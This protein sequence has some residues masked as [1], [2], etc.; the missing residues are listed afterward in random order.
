MLCYLTPNK[1]TSVLEKL[2][3]LLSKFQKKLSLKYLYCNVSGMKNDAGVSLVKVSYFDELYDVI[4]N[5]NG[6]IHK[7]GDSIL[8]YLSRRME[9]IK[10]DLKLYIMQQVAFDIYDDLLSVNVASWLSTNKESELYGKN[11]VLI[12]ENKSY[13]SYLVFDHAKSKNVEIIVFRQMNMKRNKGIRFVYY[14][15]KLISEFVRRLFTG[16]KK[17]A[18]SEEVD[19]GIPFYAVHNFT[20]F[21]DQKN[22]YLF[23]FYQS[24]ID[25]KNIL[26]YVPD[27][28]FKIS[29][30]EVLNIKKAG[31]NLLFCPTR[32]TG[33]AKNNVPVYVCSFKMAQLLLFYLRQIVKM[34]FR[35]R[36][37]PM[38]EQ[39]KLLSLLFIQLPYW[40]DFFQSNNV[41]IKFRF[42]DIF[43]IRDIAAK[44]SGV[45]TMSYHYSNHSASTIM[46]QEVCDIFYI[47]GRRYKRFLLPK[48]STT[49]NII[50]TGYV[51]DYSFGHLKQ[52]A[53]EVKKAFAG[54]NIQYVI[55]VLDE[56]LKGNPGN[57]ILDCYE[58]V[59][60]YAMSHSEIGIIIKP[61]KV[62]LREDMLSKPE[63]LDL[64]EL[65][66]KEGRLIILDYR[67]YPIEAGYASD[68][69]IGLVANSTAALECAIAGIPTIVYDCAGSRDW[70]PYYE[71]G[72]NKVVFDDIKQ[73]IDSL[74]TNRE[75][76]DNVSGF[77]DWSFILNEV[78]P[79]RDGK[80]NQRIAGYIKT[81]LL[82]S[83]NGL[84]KDEVIEA[85]NRAYAEEYGWDKVTSLHRK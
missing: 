77:A 78:D 10:E 9:P 26:I 54:R 62:T 31:F 49:K 40:E 75:I 28:E 51:F 20:N 30:E 81:L 24:G 72:Y 7:E 70:C 8:D 3:W 5:L 45:I 74:N 38:K 73:L 63:V 14:L 68:I 71:W 47:W 79:F 25:P 48:Y 80:A 66:E 56:H 76:L 11:P 85:A 19:I 58:A 83:S 29:D 59:F 39:W 12:L 46:H 52:K 43:G 22:Y 55:G 16:K 17:T 6:M 4:N 23:W 34:Y 21:F 64:L 65:L 36:G 50:Q 67:K 57:A 18:L 32:I 53:L 41:K 15:V 69:V 84:S 42:H 1:I 13:W 35:V 2:I 60:R 27:A 82:A 37:R 44:L 33:K 61:K